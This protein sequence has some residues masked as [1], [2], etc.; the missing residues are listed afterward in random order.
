MHAVVLE[1]FEEYLAG[2]LEPADTPESA[3]YPARFL[4]DID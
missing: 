2:D 4:W 1:N 3:M